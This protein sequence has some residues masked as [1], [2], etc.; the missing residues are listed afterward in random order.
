MLRVAVGAACCPAP[1]HSPCLLQSQ[2]GPVPGAPKEVHASTSRPPHDGGG[3]RRD[4]TASAT[5][6]TVGSA[7][8]LSS[9]TTFARGIRQHPGQREGVDL[10]DLLGAARRRR[11]L[12]PL[13]PRPDAPVRPQRSDADARPLPDPDQPRPHRPDE[14]R[15][16]D[17]RV[18]RSR[19]RVAG[20]P[21]A[22]ARG[23]ASPT[24]RPSRPTT[25]SSPSSARR[26]C[27]VRPRRSSARSWRPRSTTAP[28]RSPRRGRTSPFRRSSPTRRSPSSLDGSQ[29]PRR[30]HRAR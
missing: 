6:C 27:P 8:P 30:H 13:D 15:A 19:P 7:G 25:S 11:R 22:C 4:R 16:R 29:G 24:A 3:D 10:R 21:C 23:S 1:S 20:S 28:S 12:R 14:G 18:L 26:G 9:A 17:G 5:A 2:S